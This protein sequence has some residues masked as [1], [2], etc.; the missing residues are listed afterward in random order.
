M[1]V[2][3]K[4]EIAIKALKNKYTQNLRTSVTRQ[5]FKIV[6]EKDHYTEKDISDFLAWA[7][8]HYAPSSYRTVAVCIRWFAKAVL[9]IELTQMERMNS[10]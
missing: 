4:T 8:S 5:F 9:G 2:R 6:E 7:R 10:G 1:D 3:E